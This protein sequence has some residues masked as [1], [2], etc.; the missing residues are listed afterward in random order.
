MKDY[1]IEGEIPI[2]K[3]SDIR[4]TGRIENIFDQVAELDRMH[5]KDEGDGKKWRKS[6]IQIF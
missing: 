3:K 2:Y 6:K 4:Q 1:L 5:D